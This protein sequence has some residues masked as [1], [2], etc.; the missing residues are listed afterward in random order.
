MTYELEVYFGGKDVFW[1]KVTEEEL[2]E[3][4]SDIDDDAIVD[5]IEVYCVEAE[6]AIGLHRNKIIG[7]SYKIAKED[8]E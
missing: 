5:F 6:K 8:T 2:Q 1:I 4:R 7:Y 3:F